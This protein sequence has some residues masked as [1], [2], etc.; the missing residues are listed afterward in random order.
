MNAADLLHWAALHGVRITAT[1]GNLHVDAPAGVLTDRLK[2]CLRESKSE[3][4]A[5]LRTGATGNAVAAGQPTEPTHPEARWL[6]GKDLE[7]VPKPLREFV[8]ERD[9]WTPHRWARYLRQRADGCN[10][11]NTET[12]L[13][14]LRAVKLLEDANLS[15]VQ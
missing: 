2:E 9:G 13:L 12:R 5:L 14:Y 1:D 7:R 6:E 3:L 10:G 8:C 4:L 15:V 11:Q